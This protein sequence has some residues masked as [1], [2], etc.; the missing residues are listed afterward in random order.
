MRLVFSS[1]GVV[2]GFLILAVTGDGMFPKE[3]IAAHPQRPG[4]FN[5]SGK[6][7]LLCLVTPTLVYVHTERV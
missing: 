2:T 6:K 4:K 7:R 1:N 3:R 5:W